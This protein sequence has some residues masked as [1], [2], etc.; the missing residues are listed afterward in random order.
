VPC[1]PTWWCYLRFTL[2]RTTFC[3]TGTLHRRAGP[4]VHTILPHGGVI[5]PLQPATLRV[6]HSYGGMTTGMEDATTCHSYLPTGYL[7]AFPTCLHYLPPAVGATLRSIL[8]PLAHCCVLH[9]LPGGLPHAATPPTCTACYRDSW[10]VHLPACLSPPARYGR[11]YTAR[12]PAC[13]PALRLRSPAPLPQEDTLNAVTHVCHITTEL[14]GVVTCSL[15]GAAHGVGAITTVHGPPEPPRL[16]PAGIPFHA[17]LRGPAVTA[18]DT[19][20]PDTVGSTYRYHTFHVARHHTTAVTAPAA[21]CLP[22]CHHHHLRYHFR[23]R[24]TCSVH[25]TFPVL[26]AV[27]YKPDTT[28]EGGPTTCLPHYTR[29]LPACAAL[30]YLQL[31]PPRYHHHHVTTCVTVPRCRW[32]LPPACSLPGRATTHRTGT[33]AYPLQE[34]DTTWEEEAT[35]HIRK[36]P[37]PTTG[38]TCLPATDLEMPPHLPHGE[39]P[40]LGRLRSVH[41]VPVAFYHHR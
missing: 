5:P 34:D 24:Y 31:H 38:H 9:Y 28:V 16:P 3:S 32:T 11:T 41:L 25:H 18:G 4:F 39:S 27:C 23:L 20:L 33:F 8:G 36:T 1:R 2:H 29:Y 22:A 40:T 6:L 21:T 12:L 7:F 13:L 30:F 10:R 17:I 37:L 15:P 35:L 19:C 26:P 14:P